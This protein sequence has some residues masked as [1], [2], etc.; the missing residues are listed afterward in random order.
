LEPS[1]GKRELTSDGAALHLLTN[2]EKLY[3]FNTKIIPFPVPVLQGPEIKEK[4]ASATL[5]KA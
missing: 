4:T 5:C 3:V 2:Y 1:F